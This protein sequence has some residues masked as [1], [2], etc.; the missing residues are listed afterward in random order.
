MELRGSMCM[1]GVQ[2]DMVEHN[3]QELDFWTHC[4]PKVICHRQELS[5]QAWSREGF[6]FL[7]YLHR[8]RN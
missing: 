6:G 7:L 1:L 4:L 8:F 5:E 3:F 2:E